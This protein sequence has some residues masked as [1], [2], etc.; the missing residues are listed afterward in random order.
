MDSNECLN[1]FS[2]VIRDWFLENIGEPSEPQKKGWPEI[3][4]G[5]N[6]LLC[7]P[8]GSGKTFA[9]FLKCL[10]W[11]YTQKKPG[12]KNTGIRIVYISPLKALNNDIYRNLELPIKGIR[13]RA[14][15]LG[16]TLPDIEVA[17][18]TGDTPQKDRTRMLKYPPDILIT[19]PESLYIMLTSE[20]YRKLFSTAEY[21]I[22]DEIHSICA[23]KR[24]VHLAVTIER[25][26][27]IAG[28]PLQ[29][30]GLTATINPL[31]EAAR[32]L[33]GNNTCAAVAPRDITIINCDRRRSFEL[34]VSLPV[35]DMKVLPDNTIWPA[36]FAELLALVKAHKSTLMFHRC[37]RG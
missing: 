7:A 17:V 1:G 28:K 25:L 11:I 22:V 26:E 16:Q 21:L 4:S 37:C 18:R 20:S 5:R 6:V 27:R 23:N 10:D 15:F 3:A 29:R 13:Q 32:F 33:A 12:T 14:E 19:T 8:T 9:A 31:E 36:I 24:G 35:K 30:I 34:T 2:P